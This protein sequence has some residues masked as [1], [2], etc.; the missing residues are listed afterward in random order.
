MSQNFPPGVFTWDRAGSRWGT[1]GWRQGAGNADLS[2]MAVPG[3]RREG[4]AKDDS[5]R[6][7]SR[8]FLLVP[9]LPAT[10]IMF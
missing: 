4:E 1:G 9:G 2:L 5:P 10:R 7:S 3:S 8:S 6:S